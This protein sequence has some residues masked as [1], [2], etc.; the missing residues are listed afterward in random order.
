L[1]VPPV[2]R[3]HPLIEA[4]NA[5]AATEHADELHELKRGMER[6]WNAAHQ[7]I[8]GRGN[9][10]QLVPSG[11]VVNQSHPGDHVIYVGEVI[12]GDMGNG[13]ST[14]LRDTGMSYSG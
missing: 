5:P 7:F 14:T 11:R 12:G 6:R 3:V 8:A 13:I 4:P 9:T 1:D 2:E 10:F